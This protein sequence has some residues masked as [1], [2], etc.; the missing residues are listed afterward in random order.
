[1]C[2]MTGFFAKPSLILCKLPFA[3]PIL[4]NLH[5]KSHH[6]GGFFVHFHQKNRP[7]PH[8]G[9]GF[10]LFC[11]VLAIFFA[12]LWLFCLLDK[13]PKMWYNSIVR[14]GESGASG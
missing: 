7:F 9:A 11:T 6:Y 1:L 4:C 5:R 2:E 8:A 10:W 13:F 3:R 12:K 14:R